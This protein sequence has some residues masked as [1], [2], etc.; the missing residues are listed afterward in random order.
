[1]ASVGSRLPRLRKDH[2]GI[3]EGDFAGSHGFILVPKYF[4][5]VPEVPALIAAL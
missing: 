2:S 5:Q 1:M 4:C 3:S